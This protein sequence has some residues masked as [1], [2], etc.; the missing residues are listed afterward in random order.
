MSSVAV[1]QANSS[2]DLLRNLTGITLNYKWV[3]VHTLIPKKIDCQIR[4]RNQ[5]HVRRTSVTIENKF[6]SG[7]ADT[8]I[9]HPYTVSVN[10]WITRIVLENFDIEF[11][12]KQ[13]IH[14]SF[15]VSIGTNKK[16]T[17]AGDKVP[18]FQG[19]LLGLLGGPTGRCQNDYSPSHYDNYSRY[20][21]TMCYKNTSINF[22]FVSTL[23]FFI[24]FLSSLQA[25]MSLLGP[26]KLT[27]S[28]KLLF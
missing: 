20:K 25:S 13:R 24:S 2:L 26:S 6:C 11:S 10:W 7:W 9:T 27:V 21:V 5:S 17:Q 23:N 28:S 1:L 4:R 15:K 8:D 14:Q 18:P 22:A 19:W 16:I 12:R 3:L